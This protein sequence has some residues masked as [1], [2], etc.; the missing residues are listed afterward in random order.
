M[1]CN[2]LASFYPPA[3]CMHLL[4][5]FV[6]LASPALCFSISLLISTWVV[7]NIMLQFP[8]L[9]ANLVALHTRTRIPSLKFL[10]DPTRATTRCINSIILSPKYTLIQYAT[11]GVHCAVCCLPSAVCCLL[12]AFCCP[13]SSALFGCLCFRC[14]L[15]CLLLSD[16]TI[17]NYE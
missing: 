1:S 15:L 7:A 16:L 10:A 4:L 2:A 3:H 5:L 12:S 17:Y 13:M 8:F 11:P 6:A 14:Y 9:Y